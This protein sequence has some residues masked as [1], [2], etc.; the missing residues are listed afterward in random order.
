MTQITVELVFGEKAGAVWRALNQNGPSNITNLVKT[1]SLSREEV[2]SALGWLGREDKI[3]LEQK[4]REMI[5]S[6]R[7][8]ELLLQA[9]AEGA[10]EA[11]EKITVEEIPLK[12]K[13]KSK[14]KRAK[15]KP[16]KKPKKAEAGKGSLKK[17]ECQEKSLNKESD[18]TK[19]FLLH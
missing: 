6:L 12:A 8:P 9:A 10:A 19:D 13:A 4:G 11:T 14:T 16:P 1:T 17:E 5:F 2:F 18:R 15:A 7:D 3:L